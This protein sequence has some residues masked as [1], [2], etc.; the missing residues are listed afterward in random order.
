[1]HQEKYVVD[2]RSHL[3]VTNSPSLSAFQHA[4]V[5]NVNDKNTQLQRDLSSATREAESELA[6]L[7]TK[8]RELER[9]LELERRK[10]REL[11]ETNKIKDKEYQKL[12]VRQFLCAYTTYSGSP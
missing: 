4:V 8:L 1:M 11:A 5:R 6:A 9:D 12:K 3:V 10:T 2:T 7:R